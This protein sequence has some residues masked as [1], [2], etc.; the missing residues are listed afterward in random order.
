ME[1]K[2]AVQMAE[3]CEIIEDANPCPW[4]GRK[5]YFY[6]NR[7]MITFKI[8]CSNLNCPIESFSFSCPGEAL[9]WWNSNL[10]GNLVD[11]MRSEIIEE[12][13][14]TPGFV[15]RSKYPILTHGYLDKILS[16]V[17]YMKKEE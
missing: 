13:E 15:N 7:P 14:E 3:K 6:I 16:E 12:N 8:V 17:G 11:K 9:K 4:C 1:I 5:P 2:K 10:M